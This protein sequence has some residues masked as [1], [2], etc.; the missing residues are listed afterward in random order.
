MLYS[1]EKLMILSSS[2]H[3]LPYTLLLVLCLPHTTLHSVIPAS[4]VK[5]NN[6]NSS[7]GNHVK[8]NL[9]VWEHNMNIC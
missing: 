3:N 7:R 5:S 8:V 4:S 9:T 2:F 1:P 6:G